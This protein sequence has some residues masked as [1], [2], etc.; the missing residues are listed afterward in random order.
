M[1]IYLPLM[2]QDRPALQE[3]RRL[4]DLDAGRVAWAVTAEASAD[5]PGQDEEDLEYEAMQDAVHVAFTGAED[6][7]RALVIA[8]DVSD[9]VLAAATEDGGAFGIRLRERRSAKIASFH[10]TEQDRWA[11]EKD[12]TDPALLWFDAGE[13]Q[14][15]LAFRDSAPTA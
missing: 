14:D 5:R 8:A 13:G 1:R 2:A 12:D 10:V 15:A 6:A 3:G 11:A 7:A 4:V 9:G